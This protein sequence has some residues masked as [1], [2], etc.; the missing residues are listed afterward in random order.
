[1]KVVLKQDVVDLGQKGEI[2]EVKPG[3]ARNFLFPRNLA[4]P[5][6][7]NKAQELFSARQKDESK[8]QNQ[9]ALVKRTIAESQ[10][11]KL[12]FKRKAS[13][14]GK[15]FAGVKIVEIVKELEKLTGL[16][17]EALTP[18]TSI[19]KIG[20]HKFQAR[21]SGGEKLNFVVLIKPD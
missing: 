3:Y 6:D 8:K 7:S 17:P 14:E 13:S 10:G 5:A 19:K 12:F 4:V 20:E 1:M 16:K 15:L 18:R 9:I 11:A 2:K 21:F